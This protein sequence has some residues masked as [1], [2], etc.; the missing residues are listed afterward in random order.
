MNLKKKLLK[1]FYLFFDFKKKRKIFQETNKCKLLS[2]KSL[3]FLSNVINKDLR[4]ST[5][6]F[7]YG[8]KDKTLNNF[9]VFY[10]CS[11]ALEN[12]NFFLKKTKKK[13]ILISGD[14]DRTISSQ[15]EIYKE[16]LNN[17]KLKLWYAQNCVNPNKKIKQLPIGLDYIS[18]FHDSHTFRLNIKNKNYL[19][20]NYE[21]KLI[22]IINES[23]KFKQRS[24]LIYC[25]YH[26]SL[27]EGDR[28]ECFKVVDKNLCF[29]L[30]KKIPYLE[31]FQ[32]QTNFKFVLA[33]TGQGIDTH[34]VWEALLLGNIPIVKSSPLDNLY[35]NFPILIVK[36]WRDIDKSKL[37]NFENEYLKKSYNYEKLLLEYWRSKILNKNFQKKKITK[38]EKFK[39]Y[40][41]TSNYE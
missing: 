7:I 18:Q 40:L 17:K 21:K 25:N 32:K 13:F 3:I 34:R 24:N 15:M 33:P 19:P 14:S 5:K 39:K 16:I 35:Q 1:I 2:S 30:E 36:S 12:F 22:K 9:D 20:L 26:F 31:N 28:E 4:S 37:I 38:Y 10:I 41:I 27:Y 8:G 11:D 23:K 29:F 6:Y